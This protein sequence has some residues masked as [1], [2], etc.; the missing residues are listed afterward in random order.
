MANVLKPRRGKASTLAAINPVLENGEV[1]FEIPDEGVGNGLGR[2]KI[3]DG[4]RAW[5]DLEYFISYDPNIY[6]KEEEK[7]KP[8]GVVPLN[9]SKLI[10]SQYLPSF[11]DEVQEYPSFDDFPMPGELGKIYIDKSKTMDNVYRWGGTAY[12]TIAKSIQYSLTKEGGAVILVGT[13]GSKSSINSIGGVE[14]R[15]TDPTP[16]ELYAGKIWLIKQ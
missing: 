7:G 16:S 3:G 2:V 6:I 9:S 5:N 15:T 12:F 14:V 13:D 10:D 4:V 1:C 11:V 8:N